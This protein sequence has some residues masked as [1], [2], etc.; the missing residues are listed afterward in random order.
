[1]NIDTLANHFHIDAPKADNEPLVP[2]IYQNVKF[3]FDKF[4]KVKDLFEGRREGYFYSRYKNPTVNQ[5]EQLLAQAQGTESGLA[6]GSGVAA[7]ST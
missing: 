4:S 6:T 3:T 2:P 1:M 5:L 7:I